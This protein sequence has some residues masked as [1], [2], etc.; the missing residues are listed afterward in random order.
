MVGMVVWLVV[1]TV[2]GECLVKGAPI[3]ELAPVTVGLMSLTEI[4]PFELQL[5]NTNKGKTI[6]QILRI[7]FIRI[8]QTG[9]ER[10]YVAKLTLV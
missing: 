8:S 1:G 4:A 3:G 5:T 10:L 2:S 6:I 7:H 9:H